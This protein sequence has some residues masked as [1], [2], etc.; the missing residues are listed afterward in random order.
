MSN[1][2]Y[3][4]TIVG[5]G[6][7]GALFAL[8]LDQHNIPFALIDAKAAKPWPADKPGKAL[9]LSDTSVTLL[10][11]LG[12]WEAL[13][14]KAVAI[15]TVHVSEAGR[16]GAVRMQAKDAGLDALGYVINEADVWAV[17]SAAL[18]TLNATVFRPATVTAIAPNETGHVLTLHTDN[19]DQTLNAALVIAADGVSSPLRALS[20][21]G[22]D[23]K[24]YHEQALVTRITIS[25]DHHN[26]AYERFSEKGTLALMP[27]RGNEIALIIT[28]S[29][30][31]IEH[32]QALSDAEFLREVQRLS[33]YRL[34]EMLSKTASLCFPLKSIVAKEQA[35]PGLIL[36]GAS[37]HFFHPAAAQGLNLSLREAAL[38]LDLIHSS[39]KQG[40]PLCSQTLSDDYSRL[41]ATIQAPVIDMTESIVKRFHHSPGLVRHAG[42]LAV[43]YLPFLQKKFETTGLGLQGYLA[44]V[45]RHKP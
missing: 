41:A 17:V 1:T 33:G 26:V 37:A 21:I 2:Y 3:D 4:I 19:G 24:D 44:K 22:V 40:E 16:F 25:G 18:A 36:L 5:A 9:A 10:K 8:L 34:G 29:N 11:H 28:A 14:E 45:L 42:L 13:R 31:R 12:L 35:R 32:W 38:L 7:T 15:N 6:L 30:E 43:S 23:E 39:R 20:H 27:Q